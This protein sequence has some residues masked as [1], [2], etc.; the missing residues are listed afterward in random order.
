MLY[1][2]SGFVS[3]Y[4]AGEI[5]NPSLMLI[6]MNPTAR[7]IASIESWTGIRRPWIGTKQVWKMFFEI[8]LISKSLLK[9][10]LSIKSSE[11]TTDLAEELYLSIAKQGVYITNFAKCTLSNA[12]PLSNKIY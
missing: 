11:W 8:G 1:G 10:T 6:F 9:K 12:R 7:N 5:H 4:G 3:I 2:D